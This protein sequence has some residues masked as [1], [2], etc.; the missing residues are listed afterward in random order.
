MIFI[1]FCVS[2]HKQSISARVIHVK[3]LTNSKVRMVY[4]TFRDVFARRAI[5]H[6]TKFTCVS[7]RN[8][9]ECKKSKKLSLV[10]T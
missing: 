6:E 3:T 5:S 1:I 7:E 4:V 2:Y 10:E 8:R 9:K